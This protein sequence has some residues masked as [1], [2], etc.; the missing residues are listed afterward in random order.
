MTK[1]A[2]RRRAE[3][4]LLFRRLAGMRPAAAWR[5]VNPGANCT[6]DSAAQLTRRELAWLDKERAQERADPNRSFN[7]S[8]SSS[9]PSLTLGLATATVRLSVPTFKQCAGVADRGCDERIT[10]RRTRCKSC[11][12][13]HRRMK[14]HHYNRNFY[15]THQKE[16]TERRRTRYRKEREI[17]VAEVVEILLTQPERKSKVRVDPHTGRYYVKT[18]E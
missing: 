3:Q 6:D 18:D 8:M 9:V 4:L 17:S 13:E 7:L 1:P 10:A 12:A 14:R 2:R 15:Q 5:A 16:L 11:A